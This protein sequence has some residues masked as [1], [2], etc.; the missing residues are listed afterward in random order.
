MQTEIPGGPHPAGTGPRCEGFLL[1]ASHRARNFRRGHLCLSEVRAGLPS[2]LV[3]PPDVKSGAGGG[4]WNTS[5][6][7]LIEITI[8][9]K[10][11]PLK[12]G[13]AALF[14]ATEFVLSGFCPSPE[15]KDRHKPVSR[16]GQ[17]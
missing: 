10:I 13:R 12:A 3:A 8:P 2:P 9:P 15:A 17:A 7:P 6:S 14:L 5:P 16:F 11:P 4:A 1:L